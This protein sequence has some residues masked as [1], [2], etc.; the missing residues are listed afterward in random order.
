MNLLSKYIFQ[1]LN[2]SSEMFDYS[3]QTIN[4][5]NNEFNLEDEEDDEKNNNDSISHN[6]IEDEQTNDI[7]ADQEDDDDDSQTK[8][9]ADFN[10]M[11][12]CEQIE[13]RQQDSYFKVKINGVQ[14]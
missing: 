12:I 13:P 14:K 5:D 6:L 8:L 4:N 9:E 3:R 2:S 11:K 7:V 1:Q 10:G